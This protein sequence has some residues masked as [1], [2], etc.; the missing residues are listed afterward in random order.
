MVKKEILQLLTF[1]TLLFFFS[2]GDSTKIQSKAVVSGTVMSPDEREV[3]LSNE[4]IPLENEWSTVTDLTGVST[5]I[6][7][8]GRFRFEIEIEKPSFYRI[9]LGK[10]NVSLYVSPNDSIAIT[11]DSLV[12][13]AGTNAHLNTYLKN[14]K[15]EMGKTE[16]YIYRNLAS[17]Y[18]LDEASFRKQLD[19]L[20][21]TNLAHYNTFSSSVEN[22]PA[23]FEKHC[24]VTLDNHYKYYQL[25]YPS[26]HEIVTGKT[27]QLPKD[28]L[29]EMALG[30]NKPESLN[31]EKYIAYLDK[32][33]EIMSS[34]KFKNQRY[35]NQPQEKINARYL[36]IKNLP[37]DQ[38]IKDYLFEQHFKICNTNY[39]T[40]AWKG[41]FTQFE[42][43]T[44]N[45]QLLAKVKNDYQKA[46]AVREE[47]NKISVYK[48]SDEIELDA[49]IFYPE[50]HKQEDEKSAY[51]YFHG[52]GWSLGMPEAG[53]D[54]CKRMSAQGMVAIS[55][56]YR[57]IDVHG[58][59]IQKSLEDA[60]SAIRWVRANASELGIDPNKIVATGFSAGAHLAASTAIVDDFISEDNNGF[61]SVPNLV[62][63]QSSSYDLTKGD[64]WFDGVSKGQAKAISLVQ[65]VKSGLPPFLSFHTTE[66]YLAPIYE[67]FQFK[68]AMEG[69]KNDFQFQIFEKGGHFFRDKEAREKVKELTDEFLVARGFLKDSKE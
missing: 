1:G 62:I 56:E 32:Y 59:D 64:G 45:E 14:Q 5:T 41:I 65:N 29:D 50:K 37:V 55:F 30:L 18:A 21:N 26:G 34:G 25:L 52:G 15:E 69:Y 67:F 31:D 51:L 60:K 12:N 35:D 10:E 7:D 33:L 54:V 28:Y 11:L 40:K 17:L 2:C 20:K 9:I 16:G 23:V 57:L 47:P 36:A 49:H 63:T 53:Y 8:E 43:E 39:S 58:N 68:A 42:K 22:I 27:A 13:L 6:D 48:T 38:E 24:M 44:S 66:D 46:L 61:S 4:P 3:R 19:S